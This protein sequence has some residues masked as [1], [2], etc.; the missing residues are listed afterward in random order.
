MIPALITA[1]ANIIGGVMSYHGQQ[2]ANAQAFANMKHQN[3]WQEMMFDKANAYN[4]PSAQRARYERAGINPYMALGNI[5]PGT[6]QTSSAPSPAPVGNTMEGVATSLNG[7]G[8][9]MMQAYQQTRLNDAQIDKLHAE[10]ESIRSSTPYV[11]AEAQSRI[12]LNKSQGELNKSHGDLAR[13][14]ILFKNASVERMKQLTPLEAESFKANA[15][16]MISD[17]RLADVRTKID[18]FELKNI[19]PAEAQLLKAQL[20]QAYANVAYLYSLG[21]LNNAN[22]ALVLQQTMTEV[23]RRSGLKLDNKQTETLIKNIDPNA[24]SLRSLQSSQAKNADANSDYLSGKAARE[25][26]QIGISLV[27]NLMN[28]Y[29]QFR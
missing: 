18:T 19:K 28:G 24:K 12:D 29:G 22:A 20:S 13:A 26:S 17:A 25:W 3:R 6:A 27:N 21:K 2:S 5:T 9:S 4:D 1:A 16:K 15:S 10:A 14:E 7:L 23:V 11:G 8:A